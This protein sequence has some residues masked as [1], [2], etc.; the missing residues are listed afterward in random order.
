MA[1]LS[2][3][4]KADATAAT[5]ATA[6]QGQQLEP[7]TGEAPV[8]FRST[9]PDDIKTDPSLSAFKSV[10][11]LAKSYI[12]TKSLVGVDTVKKLSKHHTVEDRTKFLRDVLSLPAELE[13]YDVGKVEGLDDAY[14]AEIKKV[15]FEMGV[16]PDVFSSMA[17]KYAELQNQQVTKIKS[18]LEDR[19]KKEWS[20]LEQKYGK[21]LDDKMRIARLA[22]KE[23]VGDDSE[24]LQNVEKEMK[25]RG[26]GNA[27]QLAELFV[28]M[29]ESMFKEDVIKGKT[30][31]SI[32][33]SPAEA[34]GK[35][36]D[37][38]GDKSH[39]F[40]IPDHPNHDA[41][42]KEVSKLYEYVVAGEEV[43]TE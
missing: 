34:Q 21:A 20:A 25:D 36:N 41:A 14:L 42:I 19:Q 26:W 23:L 37:I 6:T 28:R 27:P 8:D 38:Y 3:E 29:G 43:E 40:N 4:T 16:P 33:L 12:H 31:G 9:L 18:D 22:I 35:I 1:I 17:K 10:E 7:N 13:K 2:Q 11:E 5:D 32:G 24:L 30:S 39:P 15:A